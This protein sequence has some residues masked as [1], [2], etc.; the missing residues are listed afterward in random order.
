MNESIE[1]KYQYTKKCREIS[2]FGG[3]YE[4]CCKK[5]VIAGMQW[6]DDHPDANPQYGNTHRLHKSTYPN[7]D[8]ADMQDA[9]NAAVDYQC[10]AAQMHSTTI[11][12]QYARTHG[13]K[14]YIKHMELIS[15]K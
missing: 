4:E 10:T 15:D 13:W 9:M 6:I 5:M 11:H 2:G 3:V 8:M 1:K 12:V 14:Q 7:K